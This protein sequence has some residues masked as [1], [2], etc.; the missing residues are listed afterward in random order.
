[1]E[2]DMELGRLTSREPHI[3]RSSHFKAHFLNIVPWVSL[4]IDTV[5][6]F[7]H[8]IITKRKYHVSRRSGRHFSMRTHPPNCHE[9]SGDGFLWVT[10]FVVTAPGA[11][12]TL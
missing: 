7:T 2:L 8:P 9:A 10:E 11:E 1:M 5:S 3:L 4:D 6:G 12:H